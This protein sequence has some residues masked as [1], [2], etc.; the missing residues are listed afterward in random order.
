MTQDEAMEQQVRQLCNGM[1]LAAEDA[2]GYCANVRNVRLKKKLRELLAD[3]ADYVADVLE[4][5]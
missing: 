2:V 1:K 5:P 4:N 3:T